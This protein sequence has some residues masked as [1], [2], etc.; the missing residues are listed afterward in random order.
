V[1]AADPYAP[2][3]QIRRFDGS[4]DWVAPASVVDLDPTR[5]SAHHAHALVRG[6]LTMLAMIATIVLALSLATRGV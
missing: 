6:V 3:M 1:W 5:L 4:S 2:V